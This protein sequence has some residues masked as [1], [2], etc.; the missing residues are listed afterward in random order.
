MR[1]VITS[2]TMSSLKHTGH[3][4]TI[5]WE[6]P[7][8]VNPPIVFLSG[9]HLETSSYQLRA[10]PMDHLNFQMFNFRMLKTSSTRSVVLT[11]R[12]DDAFWRRFYRNLDVNIQSKSHITM[13]FQYWLF[14]LA[15]TYV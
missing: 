9:A 3:Y 8:G 15:E 2:Q 13:A 10:D 6:F 12:G 5:C 7:S 14:N 4:R 1:C 11:G